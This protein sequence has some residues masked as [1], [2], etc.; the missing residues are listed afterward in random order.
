M[1]DNVMLDLETMGNGPNAAITAIGAV[2]FDLE[3]GVLG[4]EFYRIVDLASSVA[5]GGVMDASTVLWWLQQ[6]DEARAMYREK[7]DHIS[8]VL[9]DFSIRFEEAGGKYVWGNGSDFDNTILGSAYRRAMLPL[10]WWYRH[11]RCYRTVRG[12]YPGTKVEWAG[13]VKHNALDD[14]KNQALHLIK[15]IGGNKQ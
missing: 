3:A 14:A 10:P 9:R 4:P 15:L 8:E 2:A 12:M 13:G 5:G 6:S 11:N 1:F 7:G